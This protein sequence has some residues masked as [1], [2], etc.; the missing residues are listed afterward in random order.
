MIPRPEAFA[1]YITVY[2]TVL[3]VS[4]FPGPTVAVT[5]FS[6]PQEGTGLVTHSTQS[7]DGNGAA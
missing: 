4:P 2:I 5:R 1:V 6:G 7:G 3:L